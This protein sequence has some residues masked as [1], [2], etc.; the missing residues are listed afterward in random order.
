LDIKRDIRFRVYLSFTGIVLLAIAVIVKAAIIQFSEGEELRA[1]AEKARTKSEILLP[2]R[3]NIYTESGQVLSSTIPQ[4]DLRIDF[5]AIDKD[6]FNTYVDTLAQCIANLFKDAPAAAYRHQLQTA[7]RKKERYWLL[8]KNAAYYQYQEARHFPI[9]NKGKNRGGFIAEAKSKR[10]NPYGMLAYRTIGLWRENVDNI[11]LEK[12]YD[13]TLSGQAGSRVVRKATGNVW[14]PIEGSEIDPVNGRDIVTTIDIDI[15]DIAEHALLRV[16]EANKCQYGTVIVMETQTGKIRALANLGRQADGSYWE[17]FNYAMLPS[18]PGSTF[19]LMSLMALLDDG[20]VTIND[21]VNVQGG[22]AYFGGQRVIDDHTGM[23]TVPVITAFAKSSNVAFAKLI[24]DKYSKDP[25]KYIA[26]LQKLGL[27]KP[28]GVDIVGER[29]PLIKT[30][31]HS[32]WNKV[33]SLPWIAYG[34]ESLITP[35]HTCMVYNAVANN[36]KLMKPYLVSAIREYGHERKVAPVV[37]NESI[38][39]K[40]TIEQMQKAMRAVVTDGTAKKI[41][42]PYYNAAGKTGT[43]QVADKGITYA[44][45]VRQGSFVGYFPYEKPQ[46][47]IAVVVRSTPHGPYYGAVVGAP[48]FKEIADKLYANHVGGWTIPSDSTKARPS[49]IAKNATADNMAGVLRSLGISSPKY[50]GLNIASLHSDAEGKP[51]IR[52]VNVNGAQVPDVTGMGLKD[53]LFILE[54]SGLTVTVSGSGK[55]AA[56][57]LTAGTKLIKGQNIHLQLS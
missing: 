28:T 26:H 17:D 56:Q 5:K 40:S 37:L 54:N 11:G 19:K 27:D 25:M 24:N 32:R 45:G 55:V 22:I 34:Y 12:T 21:P 47:T 46:Y 6:T 2:E 48:V 31:K 36:G 29:K 4:F 33:T 13:S 10:V 18:E 9:F 14:I 20:Y 41:Q 38:A 8:K 42:S 16:L 39:K 52:G 51:A 15:Q 44:D 43:A 3:G 57:S 35:L 1:K 23:G 53:A 49:W 50:S 30:T 7:F